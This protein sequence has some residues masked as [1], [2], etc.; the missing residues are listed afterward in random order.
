M[1]A[2]R[3]QENETALGYSLYAIPGYGSAGARSDAHANHVGASEFGA[4]N[5]PLPTEG[6]IAGAD[7]MV[8][9]YLPE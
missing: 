1:I 4:D 3:R 8:F 5:I 2:R 9:D 6:Y 7:L